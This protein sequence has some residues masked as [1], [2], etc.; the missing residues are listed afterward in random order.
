[1]LRIQE[2]YI[3]A[4]RQKQCVALLDA[5]QRFLTDDFKAQHPEYMSLHRLY[6]RWAKESLTE[7]PTVALIRDAYFMQTGDNAPQFLDWS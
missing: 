1:M 3:A 7:A 5:A 2:K 6:S 4:A